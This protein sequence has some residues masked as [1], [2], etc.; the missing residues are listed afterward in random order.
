MPQVLV[1]DDSASDRMLAGAILQKVP[2]INVAYAA[3]GAEALKMIEQQLP[4]AVVTD[5]NMPELDGLQLVGCIKQGY[6]L[7]PV[8]L[9][10]AQGSEEIA[11]EA[12]RLGAA[13]YVP[14][15][16]LARQLGDVVSRIVSAAALD[17]GHTRLMHALAECQCR[18]VLQNDP[19]L[20]EPLISQLQEML[21]CLPLS[22]ESERLRVGIAVKHAIL[23][24]LYHGN[25]ELPDELEDVY[26]DEGSKLV[27]ERLDDPVLSGRVLVVEAHLTPMAAQFRI[28]HEGQGFHRSQFPKDFDVTRSSAQLVRGWILMQSIMNEVQLSADGRT[29]TLIKRAAAESDLVVED[30]DDQ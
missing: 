10:T 13:S 28:H 7:L 21:R 4:D 3:D 8:I 17:R 20:I 19:G 23:N 12:L 14:K 26:S 2:G 1:V 6:P 9:M 27:R 22:D 18:F 30:N 11:A 5:L 25:L 24:G 29:Q 16:L 15:V